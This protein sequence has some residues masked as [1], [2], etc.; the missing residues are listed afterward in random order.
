MSNEDMD[1]PGMSGWMRSLGSQSGMPALPDPDSLWMRAQISARHAAAAR[2]LRLS[3]LRQGLHF[4]I[5]GTGVVWLLLECLRGEGSVLNRLT[6]VMASI[7]AEPVV[8]VAITAL[9]AL[10]I[11]L[12]ASALVLGRSTL[13]RRLRYLGLY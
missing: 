7:S 5:L 1:I 10:G 6:R 3:T 11:A 2:T 8:S 4:A 13:A 12:L 9:V